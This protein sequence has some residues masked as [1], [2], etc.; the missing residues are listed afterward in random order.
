[1][2]LAAGCGTPG[3]EA[4]SGQGRARALDFPRNCIPRGWLLFG[5][6]IEQSGAWVED[7]HGLP[8]GWLVQIGPE[9]GEQQNV[10]GHCI[11]GVSALRDASMLPRFV[12]REVTAPGRGDG[13][14]VSCRL[15]LTQDFESFDTLEV[16]MRLDRPRPGR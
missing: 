9:S 5:F 10:S 3:Q 8:P 7:V 12:I 4:P 14:A 1:M 2:L 11:H 6:E 13:P 16:E 15:V